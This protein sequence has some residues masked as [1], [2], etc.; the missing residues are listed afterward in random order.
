MDNATPMMP[1]APDPC[2]LPG[3]VQAATCL[4]WQA[5][6]AVARARLQAPHPDLQPASA[7][8]RLHALGDAAFDEIV[9][10]VLAGPAGPVVRSRLG[11]GLRC[12]SSQCWARRQVPAAV[13]PPGQHPHEWHQDGAL[14]CRFDGADTT[15]LDL[16]TVWVALVPCGD[17]APSLE[18]IA[19][20]PCS[21]QPAHALSDTVLAQRFGRAGRSHA[22]LA[23]GDA[24]V[25]GGALLH[26]SHHD[27]AMTRPRDSVELR[28]V[29]AGPVPARL[30]HE[31]LSDLPG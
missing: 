28:F 15:L 13:R 30:V 27:T 8:L 19:P 16:V 2:C 12:L 29:P 14:N 9:S 22:R 20:G 21:L 24:L 3:A 31:R 7:S 26:R 17:D 11:P 18:W 5:W 23:A 6:V 4:R 1:D 25:F 10:T